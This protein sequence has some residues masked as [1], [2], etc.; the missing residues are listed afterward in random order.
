VEQVQRRLRELHL[1]AGPLDGVFGGGTQAAVKSYQKTSGLGMDGVVGPETW[2]SLFGS[3]APAGRDMSAEPL[4]RRCLALT[5]S[6]ETGC[7]VP[8]CYAGLTGDFDGQGLSLGVLQWNFGQGSL[9]PLL[10]DMISRHRT[11]AESILHDHLPVLEAVLGA[12][13]A[14]Q[15]AWARSIQDT[16][17]FTVWEPWR[18]LLK[19]LAR[20]EEFQAIEMRHAAGVQERALRMAAEY[21]LKTERG[22]ALMFDICTQNGSIS[23]AVKAQILKD[24]AGLPAG[25][26]LAAAET[27]R[28]RII[29][30]RRAAAS[31]P[32]FAEDVRTRKLTIAEGHGT[33]HGIYYDL[34][35]YGL[36]LR[37]L[38][39]AEAAIS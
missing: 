22:A 31:R 27:A 4:G 8:E 1:Y 20:S 3:E 24:F 16:R 37:A 10:E 30:T 21:G 18:G 25:A 17:R 9:Q 12:S 26:D 39:G 34:E 7:G 2:A 6:F 35:E 5:G 19:S 15:L 11:V 29:A 32:E 33:V 13:R 14:E 36:R 38:E 28:M 23:V